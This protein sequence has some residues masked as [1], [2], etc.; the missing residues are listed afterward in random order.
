MSYAIIRNEKYTKD[1]MIQ[2]APHNERFKKK[3]SNKNIDL[4]KTSQNYHLKLPKENTY[5]KEY[6][7]L[8]KEN[9]LF[10][11]QLHKNSIYVCEVILTS[12][13]T[14][15]NGIGKKETKRY[16]KECFKFM[17]EYNGIGK[18][19]I[20]TAV[21]H[22]DEETPHMHLVYMPVVNAK[23]KKGNTIRKIS[24][25]EFWKGKDSYKKLQNQFYKYI[26]EKGFDLERGLYVEETNRKNLSVKEFKKVTNYAKTKEILK[27]ATLELPNTP[28]LQDIK[29]L[30]LNRDKII[31]EKIIKPQNTLIKEL[32]NENIT[33]HKELSKQTK[34][35]DVA[36]KYEKEKFNLEIENRNLR[37]NLSMFQQEVEKTAKAIDEEYENKIKDLETK[38]KSKIDDL[39]YENSRLNKII[40]KF[41][42]NIKKFMKWLCNKFSYPCEDDFIRDFNKETYSNIDF[43][44]ELNIKQFG[45]DYEEEIDFDIY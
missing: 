13:N 43:D 29:K 12:D 34:I 14:F 21:V 25:S 20:L 16:F 22:L 45:Q 31:E 1:E 11:G 30:V 3:Y 8:I 40:D 28:E 10:Q 35:I 17:I 19:N 32:H 23:D 44:K 26:T 41:K 4:S 37:F 2:L 36:E 38:Y 7:R 24:A 42:A 33:L 39:E 15:F 9:N 18:E 6:N 27:T 5:L